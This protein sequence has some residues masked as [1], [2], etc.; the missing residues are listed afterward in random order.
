LVLKA[1]FLSTFFVFFMP[2]VPFAY[3][4]LDGLFFA[5]GF[6]LSLQIQEL[7]AGLPS[8]PGLG[9]RVAFAVFLALSLIPH[10]T[11]RWQAWN[12]TI[13]PMDQYGY[14]PAIAPAA[15]VATIQWLRQN[16]GPDDLVLAT[17]DAGPWL[18]TAPV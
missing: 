11:Y 7:T 18:A 6:L 3:H 12:A 4:A 14:P 15:E 1:W 10:A 2:G 8:V 16:A 17:Y 5:V 9:L 13:A